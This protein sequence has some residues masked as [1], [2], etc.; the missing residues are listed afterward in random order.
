[1]AVRAPV[2]ALTECSA[3][4]GSDHVAVA[5]ALQLERA[6]GGWVPPTAPTGLART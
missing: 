4:P 1:M 2:V 5:V 3:T 6:F